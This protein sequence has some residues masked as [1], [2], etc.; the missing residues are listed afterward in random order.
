[1]VAQPL[2]CGMAVGKPVTYA[3]CPTGRESHQRLFAY[4]RKN[5]VPCQY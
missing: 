3:N 2:A 1:M 5:L 4:Y